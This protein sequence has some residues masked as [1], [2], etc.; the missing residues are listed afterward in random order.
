MLAPFQAFGW[1]HDRIAP[2]PWIRQCMSEKGKK[3]DCWCD[4]GVNGVL[5]EL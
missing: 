3:L 4:S 5:R 2:L 1:G